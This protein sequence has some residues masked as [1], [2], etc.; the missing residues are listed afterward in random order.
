MNKNKTIFLLILFTVLSGC[1]S[2]EHR[3][4]TTD[5]AAALKKQRKEAALRGINW[6]ISKKD[7]MPANA[8]LSK[9]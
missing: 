3:P 8:A 4:G 6:L 1:Q 7:S 2:L 9:L 5:P